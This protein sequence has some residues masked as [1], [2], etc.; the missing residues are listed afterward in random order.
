MVNNETKMLEEHVTLAQYKC[1]KE[2]FG[3]DISEYSLRE[4]I[5]GLN[6]LIK[7]YSNT[8]SEKQEKKDQAHSWLIYLEDKQNEK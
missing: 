4:V 7:M 8:I 3:Q 1:L 6:N 2:V 5:E